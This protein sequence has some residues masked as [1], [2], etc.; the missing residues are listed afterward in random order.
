MFLDFLDFR[1]EIKKKYLRKTVLK[2][3]SQICENDLCVHKT[4][5][6]KRGEKD[7]KKTESV[8][9][10]LQILGTKNVLPVDF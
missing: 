8:H 6:R 5:F 9:N 2:M 7:R 10:L 4:T 3:W 1:E